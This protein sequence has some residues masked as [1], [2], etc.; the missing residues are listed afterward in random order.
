MVEGIVGLP[1]SGKTYLLA[2]RGLEDMKKGK[3]VYAN[4][5]LEGAIYF[6]K[7]TEVI[8]VCR[9]KL[10]KKEKISMT[11]LIDEIN[12]SFPSRMWS[13]I[14][15]WV[16]YFWSQTRKFG[17]DIYYTSQ[18]LKRVDTVIREIT[19]YVWIVK[20]FLF[21]FHF[22]SEIQ[23]EDYEKSQKTVYDR[24]WFR[25]EKKYYSQYNTFEILELQEDFLK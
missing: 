7:I 18:S 2:K 15:G 24:E 1:G 17:L 14:P 16:L 10:L 11:V 22:A 3:I 21:G 25:I 12:L 6:S 9:E 20:P 4:F 23:V 5:H 13:K 8:S 19:N